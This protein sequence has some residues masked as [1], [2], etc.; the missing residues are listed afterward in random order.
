MLDVGYVSQ[1]PDR[2]ESEEVFILCP[3][4]DLAG[5]CGV[6]ARA[7]GGPCQ[8]CGDNEFG[9]PKECYEATHDV[10]TYKIL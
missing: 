3:L 2:I 10:G 7:D 5:S 8:A 6:Q 1:I 4:W 9:G